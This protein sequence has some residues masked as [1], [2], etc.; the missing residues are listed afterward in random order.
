M[1]RNEHARAVGRLWR[2]WL[3]SGA[4]AALF[5]LRSQVPVVA[6]GAQ[7]HRLVGRLAESRL[8]PVA[9][10]N[11]SGL[12]DGEPLERVAGWADAFVEGHYQ[13]GLWHYVNIPEAEAVYS[14]LRDCSRQVGAPLAG[15]GSRWRDCVVDRIEYHAARLLDRSLDRAVAIKFLV[16]LVADV[17]QPFHALATGRGG[18]AIRV[19]L[20]GASDCPTEFG[21]TLP[22]NLHA[23]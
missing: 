19:E 14:R 6:W 16:H 15:R 5:V 18:N 10:R 2:G 20:F 12:L 23:A 9:R 7:G 17:H 11:V 8:S 13:T 3:V 22:C 21:T 1:D 4:V